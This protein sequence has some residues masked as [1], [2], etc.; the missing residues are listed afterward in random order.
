[1]VNCLCAHNL[2]TDLE[3]IISA[4]I[5]LHTA[6]NMTYYSSHI[7]AK[8]CSIINKSPH[9]H[10]VSDFPDNARRPSF[11]KNWWLMCLNINHHINMLQ[12]LDLFSHISHSLLLIG[13]IF[14]RQ[15]RHLKLS[16]IVRFFHVDHI[17]PS[18]PCPAL[19]CAEFINLC[20][21]LPL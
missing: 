14:V 2:L 15:S 16:T 17:T 1:M 11:P 13:R 10:Y 8:S 20:N 21:W 5:E 12:L 3:D 19:F 9:I 6:M 18:A 4:S 7:D